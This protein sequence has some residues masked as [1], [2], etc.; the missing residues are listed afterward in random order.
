M[1][2]PNDYAPPNRSIRSVNGMNIPPLLHL[3][4]IFPNEAR[5]NKASHM[6]SLQLSTLL[7]RIRLYIFRT[8]M[9]RKEDMKV[10]VRAPPGAR[11]SIIN[12]IFNRFVERVKTNVPGPLRKREAEWI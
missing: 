9:E 6:V 11:E 8:L 7:D 10:H 12:G 4:F 3:S 5:P 2:H 1:K